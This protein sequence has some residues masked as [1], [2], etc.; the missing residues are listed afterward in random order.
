M[1]S[2]ARSTSAVVHAPVRGFRLTTVIRGVQSLWNRC[3]AGQTKNWARARKERACRDADVRDREATQTL[4][5][6]AIRCRPLKRF[7]AA[8]AA[9]DRVALFAGQ[10]LELGRVRHPL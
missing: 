9:A 2:F 5:G 3:C 4:K 8:V 10:A 6:A 7:L 1:I